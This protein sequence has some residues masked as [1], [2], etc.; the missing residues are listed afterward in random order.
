MSTIQVKDDSVNIHGLKVEMQPVLKESRA[1]WA[2][3]GIDHVVTSARDGFHSPGSYHYYGYAV[4][5]RTWDGRQQQLGDFVR[6]DIAAKLRA[7]L[8]KYSAHYDVVVHSTHIHVE[9]DY[10]KAKSIA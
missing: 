1:I 2:A 3:H 6:R 10:F 4:D 7:A 9:Y 5:L 8:A